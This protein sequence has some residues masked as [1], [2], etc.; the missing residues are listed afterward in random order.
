[1][2]VDRWE[3]TLAGGKQ[4]AATIEGNVES[5][6]FGGVLASRADRG[7]KPDGHVLELPRDPDDDPGDPPH[8]VTVTF[9][10]RAPICVLTLDGLE[11]SPVLWPSA[12]KKRALAP[13]PPPPPAFP[14]KIIAAL[15]I[16]IAISAAVILFFRM[17]SEK[18]A[19]DESMS[20]IYRAPNGRF[21]AH[22]PA[23]FGTRAAVAPRAMSGVVLEDRTRGD[24]VVVFAAPA[25]ETQ[26]DVWAMHKRLYGEAIANLPR[27]NADH[28]ETSREEG[29]CFGSSAAVTE[30]RVTNARGESARVRACAFA[31]KGSAYLVGYMIREAAKA[32]EEKRL[33]RVADATELTELSD[34]S[35]QPR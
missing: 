23:G 14:T 25:D 13:P 9:D 32:D 12:K 3:W 1:M 11:V 19:D 29:T 6:F 21:V 27:A 20:G 15:A 30:A 34:I 28:V 17:R 24:A 22:H 18:T 2:T 16:A 10:P 8:R 7:S 33:A 4:V 5:V 31:S 35:D 26:R